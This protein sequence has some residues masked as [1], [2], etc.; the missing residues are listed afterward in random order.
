MEQVPKE[1]VAQLHELSG[2]AAAA[3]GAAVAKVAAKVVR[4]V[5]C[6]DYNVVQNNGKA[7]G[8][9]IPHVHFHIMPRFPEDHIGAIPVDK[10]GRPAPLPDVAFEG[11]V[12][13]LRD[14]VREA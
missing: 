9:E 12:K 6:A 2:G 4:A 8:Q 13:E 3:L 10:A 7:A 11:D 14:A 1:Q 5:G